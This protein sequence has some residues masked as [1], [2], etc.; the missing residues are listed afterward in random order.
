MRPPL[1]ALM[2]FSL[3]FLAG[4]A[5]NPNSS[6]ARQC[7]NGLSVAYKELDFAKAKGFDGTVEYSKAAGLLTA[8]KVQF[9]FGKYPNCIEKVDRARA[10]IS[11]SQTGG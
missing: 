8:A 2:I 10:F 4:C 11:R 7:E 1:A 9:E 5:G 3:A 6:L